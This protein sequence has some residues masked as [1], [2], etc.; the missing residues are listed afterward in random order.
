MY[1][2]IPENTLAPSLQQKPN[3]YFLIA[4][5][6]LHILLIFFSHLFGSSIAAGALGY[7]GAP[8][9]EHILGAQWILVEGVNSPPLE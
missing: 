9:L 2:K 6:T 1:L 8:C 3:F 5:N 4:H 7:V